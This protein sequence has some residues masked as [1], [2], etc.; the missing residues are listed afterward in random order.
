MLLTWSHVCLCAGMLLQCWSQF[1]RI[2][3]ILVYILFIITLTWQIQQSI[4]ATGG[5]A[6]DARN[7]YAYVP[8]SNDLTNLQKWLEDL[9]DTTHLGKVALVGNGSWPLP[10]YLRT[11]ED[12]TYWPNIR[13]EFSEYAV[14]F[15]MPEHTENADRLLLK[16]HQRLPRGLRENIAIIMYLRNDILEK[17]MRE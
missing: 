7:P 6:N 2:K 14:V 13:T 12:L 9:S 17:W 8:S 16:S 10:W 3:Q 4:K 1:T 5:N 11:I 15:V